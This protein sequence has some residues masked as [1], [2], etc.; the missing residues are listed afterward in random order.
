MS[1]ISLPSFLVETSPGHYTLTMSASAAETM[2]LCPA[3]YS[4]SR[5]TEIEAV[6]TRAGMNY[7]KYGLHE[8]LAFYYTAMMKGANLSEAARIAEAMIDKAFAEHPQP[9]SNRQGKPEWRTAARAKQALAAYLKHWGAEDFEVL[10]V[11]EPFEVE[12]GEFQT[13][14]EGFDGLAQL[15]VSVRIRGIRDLRVKWHDA[16]WVLDHKTSTEWSDLTVDEGKA[17]FQF[18]EYA[19]VEKHLAHQLK[20]AW[21]KEGIAAHG[22]VDVPLISTPVGGVIGNYIISRQPYAEGR[23]PSTRDLPRDQ[24][25]REPYPYSEAQLA[26]WH[27]D[28]MDL[29]REIFT[30]WQTQ[31]WKRNRTACAHWGRCEYY[32]LCWETDPAYR[33]A[34]ALSS[35][36]RPRTPSPFEEESNGKRSE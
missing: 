16:I 26:E 29:A 8:P 36:Y 24:F 5:V 30:R 18:Q 31:N 3:K 6:A 2:M 25:V 14:R 12:L 23:K 10:G 15:S 4:W 19:W 13:M 33:E 7:G 34:A 9:E 32:R 11:E 35:D 22:Q 20:D 17:S 21:D 28:A 1:D 27:E